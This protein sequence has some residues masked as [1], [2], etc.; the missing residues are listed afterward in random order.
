[1]CHFSYLL[2]YVTAPVLTF[3]FNFDVF[4]VYWVLSGVLIHANLIKK[5]KVQINFLMID[6]SIFSCI[7]IS[8]GPVLFFYL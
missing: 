3:A 6:L 8:W 2:A 4:L 7:L 5:K 1:M